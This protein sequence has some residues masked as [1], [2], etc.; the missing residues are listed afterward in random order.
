MTPNP[1]QL[2]FQ[3]FSSIQELEEAFDPLQSVLDLPSHSAPALPSLPVWLELR[4]PPENDRVLLRGLLEADARGGARLRLEAAEVELL[5][6]RVAVTLQEHSEAAFRITRF[7]VDG[8]KVRVSANGRVANA[9]LLDISTGG[10]LI[11]LP[12]SSAQHFPPG[13]T[14]QL[15][16]RTGILRTH[17]LMVQV[18]WTRTVEKGTFGMGCTF[19]PHQEQEIG[20]FIRA[21][22]T[23]QSSG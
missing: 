4:L 3:H 12:Q 8:R 15:R 1:R 22:L 17:L 10:C 23:P 18:A 19:L 14:M 6:T 2:L 16:L 21:V 9:H 5:K 13:Q 11:E 7:A 20:K